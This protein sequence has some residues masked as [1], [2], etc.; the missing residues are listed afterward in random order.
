MANIWHGI[1]LFFLFC[2]F[3]FDKLSPFWYNLALDCRLQ[4]SKEVN[5]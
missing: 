3:Y 5:V 4:I 2:K 1:V